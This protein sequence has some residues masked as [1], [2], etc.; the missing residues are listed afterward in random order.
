[1]PLTTAV[2]AG[3]VFALDDATSI[4]VGVADAVGAVAVA[5]AVAVA[6]TVSLVGAVAVMCCF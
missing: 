6:V 5:I 3:V 4:G 1:M 2:P